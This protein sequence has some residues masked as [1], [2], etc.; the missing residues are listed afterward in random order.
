MVI[1]ITKYVVVLT[2]LYFLITIRGF[3]IFGQTET[4]TPNPSITSSASPSPTPDNTVKQKELQEKIKEYEQKVRD[5]Q[6]QGRTLS[7]QIKIMDNQI[8]LTEYK[9]NEAKRKI[10]ELEGDIEITKEKVVDLEEDI[11]KTTKILLKRI[12]ATYEAGTSSPWELLL[13]SSDIDSFFT[14]LKYLKIVQINDK[15]II[16][17]AEQAKINYNNQKKLLEESQSEEEQLRTKLTSYTTQL[18]RDKSSKEELLSVTKNDETKYQKLLA[19]ARAQISAFKSFAS[20][21][22]GGEVSILPAQP[23]PDGWYYNQRDERWAT[24]TIGSS[25]EQM[26]DVGCLVTAT[27]MVLKKHGENIT[28]SDTANNSSNF[29]SDTAYMLIPWI[30]GKFT[31]VWVND[32]GVI[33]AKIS[34]GEPVIVGVRAGTY[35]QHFIVLKSGSNGDYIMNDP[36]YGPDLKFTE[37]YSTGQIFQYGYYKG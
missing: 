31:S 36:W 33:D 30:G 17:S 13:T 4:P 25:S 2:L 23:S 21:R 9:I 29:F 24:N 19:E 3:I 7:S 15:K 27:T 22:S 10:A 26:W 32:L 35:G 6:S 1:R 34:S 37:Y 28:P 11:D 14:R 16:F 8:L 18:N 20:S 12:S 5:L